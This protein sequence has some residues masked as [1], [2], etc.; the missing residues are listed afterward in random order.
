MDELEADTKQRP[1]NRRAPARHRR[2][3]AEVEDSELPDLTDQRESIKDDIDALEDRQGELDAELNEHQLE[4]QYAEDAVD[5]L[6]DD[7]E[8]AQNRK[9]DAR[10]RIDDLEATVAEKQELKGEKEQ[11]VADL[12]EELAELK[13]EREDLKAD[14]RKP[15]KPATSNRPR[16][17][18]RARPRLSRTLRSV[19]RG[20]R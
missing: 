7:V 1:G 14:C 11:D 18:K 19:K 8:A 13:S 4:K 16:S 15:R 3:E 20:N 6:H 5:D 10:E 9:A 12:E 17:P 2:A